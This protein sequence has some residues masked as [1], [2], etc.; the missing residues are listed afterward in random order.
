MRLAFLKQL[1]EGGLLAQAEINTAPEDG[2]WQLR[3]IKQGGEAL[4]VT[5]AAKMGQVKSYN[6]LN[7]AMMDAYRIGFRAVTV[8]LPH[9]YQRSDGPREGPVR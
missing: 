9:D 4:E 5:L 7:A 6:R 1:F 8:R 3:V 2:R